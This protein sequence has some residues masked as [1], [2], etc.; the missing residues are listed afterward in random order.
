MLPE[1]LRRYPAD[2]ITGIPARPRLVVNAYAA[3]RRIYYLNAHTRRDAA[4]TIARHKA[5]SGI[6]AGV[7]YRSAAFQDDATGTRSG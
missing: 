1:S 5:H 4:F 2:C 6:A 3:R 7:R